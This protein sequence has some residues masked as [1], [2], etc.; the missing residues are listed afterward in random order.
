M[1]PPNKIKKPLNKTGN[2]NYWLIFIFVFSFIIYANTIKNG[3]V[4]DDSV[5]IT[6]NKTVQKGF[7]GIPE[8]I[9]K[10]FYHGATGENKNLYRPIPSIFF[11]I[12]VGLFGNNPMFP[13]LVNIILFSLTCMVLFK[14]LKDN[15]FNGAMGIPF[16]AAM[17]FASHP[18]HTEVVA[19]IKS[20]DEII[21]LLGSLL[22]LYTFL[23]YIKNRNLKD[24]LYSM[25]FFII[26]I[27]SKENAITF[28]IIIPLTAYLINATKLKQLIILSLPL[29]AIAFTNIIL[30]YYLLD[31][32][33]SDTAITENSL[34]AAGTKLEHYATAILILGKYLQLIIFPQPLVWDYSFNQIPVVSFANSYVIISIGLHLL[35]LSVAA[36]FYKKKP[37][38]T[39]GILFYFVTI[40]IVSNIIIIIGTQMAERLLYMPSVGILLFLTILPFLF[41]NKDFTKINLL[42]I[43]KS[44][45]IIFIGAIVLFSVK[46]ISRNADW[47]DNITLFTKS[48]K[49]SPNSTRVHFTIGN[50]Y[51][52]MAM[53]EKNTNK[54]N[55]YFDKSISHLK[56]AIYI[57]PKYKE[58]WFF[59]GNAYF[60][61]KDIINAKIMYRKSLELNPKNLKALN[62]LGVISSMQDNN[63]LAEKLFLKAKSI[64]VNNA[65]SYANLGYLHYIQLKY[66]I[67]IIEL[68]KANYLDP[69]NENVIINLIEINNKLN[70]SERL[71]YYKTKLN[72]LKKKKTNID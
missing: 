44:I 68:E 55:E 66:K 31:S 67:A 28:L 72:I 32:N 7:A 53:D 58:A 71:E 29:I 20:L 42:E 61:K 27:F 9:T 11:A 41:Y 6:Q 26:A 65:D 39:C 13:H 36:Y 14:L 43:P 47:K 70:N 24:Y 35:L 38:I 17:L 10:S 12:E 69:E 59:L 56:R 23:N 57:Y 2:K 22:S 52:S 54:K 46:T 64:D 40:S 48:L 1:K 37:A 15:F 49:T 19:N 62:L 5:A 33:F 34:I 3:Y 16:F 50:E 21:A 30:R 51:L 45:K 25:L 60:N 4:V 18:I 8:L 63:D